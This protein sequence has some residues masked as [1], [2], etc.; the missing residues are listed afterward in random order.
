MT[1]DTSVRVVIGKTLARGVKL[2]EE[3]RLHLSR[4]SVAEAVRALDAISGGRLR[5]YM[6][7]S[8]ARRH[9]K[10]ALARKDNLLGPDEVTNPTGKGDIYILPAVKGASSGVGKIIAGVALIGLAFATGGLSLAGGSISATFLGG[11][12]ASLGASLILGGVVQLITPVPSFNQSNSD[13]SKGGTTFQGNA[14][15]IA[16]GGCV[17]LVYGR[18]LVTPMPISMAFVAVDQAIAANASMG[19]QTYTT[20]RGAGGVIN[21]VPDPLLAIENLP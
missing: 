18:M 14:G 1:Q 10:V 7:D 4:P 12:S 15:T 9:Y 11:L 5:R 8:K 2:P 3:M 17:P 6:A 16:Q 21:Y 19:I 20:T 13:D